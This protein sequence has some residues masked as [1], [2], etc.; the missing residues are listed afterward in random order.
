LV[1]LVTRRTIA[2]FEFKLSKE[3]LFETHLSVIMTVLKVQNRIFFFFEILT[4]P[5][6]AYVTNSLDCG[7]DATFASAKKNYFRLN[8]HLERWKFCDQKIIEDNLRLKV[9]QLRNKNEP[10]FDRMTVPNRIKEIPRDILADY[11][12][13]VASERENLT[14]EEEDDDEDEIEKKRSRG[15]KLLKQIH[16]RVFQK[17]KNSQNNL[18]FEDVV[19]E[20]FLPQLE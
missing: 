20:K 13:R 17:C 3:F 15:R 6:Q 9:L 1:T 18:T 14:V 7:E 8:Q 2:S 10:E 16:I 19:D 5:V 11:E 4:C 12:R